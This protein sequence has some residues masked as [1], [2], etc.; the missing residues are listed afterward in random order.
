MHTI[1]VEIKDN[2]TIETLQNPE[3]N[4]LIRIVDGDLNSPSLPGDRLSLKDFD[5]WIKKSENSEFMDLNIAREKWKNQ[6]KI[7]QTK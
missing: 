2:I 6:K 4:H 3:Q 7:F 1:T 5:A